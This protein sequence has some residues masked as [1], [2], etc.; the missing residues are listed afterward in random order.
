[1]S[2]N[3][4]AATCLTTRWSIVTD[5]AAMLLVRPSLCKDKYLIRQIYIDPT[6][7]LRRASKEHCDRTRKLSLLEAASIMSP[8][9]QVILTRG[10]GKNFLLSSVRMSSK[11]FTNISLYIK[12]V[13]LWPK[14]SSIIF[15]F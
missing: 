14:V 3:R 10:G 8:V 12:G 13:M 4:K 5:P 11:G 7:V 6:C 1:M 9:S 15:G 2:S